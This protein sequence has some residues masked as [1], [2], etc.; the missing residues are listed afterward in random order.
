MIINFDSQQSQE[1]NEDS[2]ELWE[3]V[4]Q[5]I[6]QWSLLIGKLDD[7]AALSSILSFSPNR[8][9]NAA[10][11][12]EYTIPDIS[13]MTIFNGGTGIV[14]DLVAKWIGST[15]V[16]PSTFFTAP[17]EEELTEDYTPH[18][19]ISYLEL[20]RKHF[21]FSLRSGVL[22]CHLAME[23]AEAWNKNNEKFEYLSMSIEYISLFDK[24]DFALKH[25]ICCIIWNNILRKYIQTSFKLINSIGR[26][27][28]DSK[29]PSTFNETMVGGRYDSINS[30]P[31][32][33]NVHFS[34]S[35]SPD[36]LGIV[37][38]CLNI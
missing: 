13:L 23:Y 24:S 3:Q 18:T 19:A 31:K 22:L 26:S 1:T 25:G 14:S 36:L 10:N 2:E 12:L 4:S 37:I 8:N 20:L 30:P 33:S 9:T 17:N 16:M 11:L 28:D 29:S 7:I 6:A 15:A 32:N 27:I 21:P 34:N 35:R 38:R 5:E